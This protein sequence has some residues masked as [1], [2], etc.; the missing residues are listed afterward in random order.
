MVNGLGISLAGMNAAAH[1]L[2]NSANNVANVH[3]AAS[4]SDSGVKK[5]AFQPQNIM[6]QSVEPT[7]GVRTELRTKSNAT[8]P[9]S[10]PNNPAADKNG[11]VEYPNVNLAEEVVSQKMATYDYKANLKAMETIDSIMQSLLDVTA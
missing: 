9:V 7:G 6:R 8:V 10:E 11:M 1:Q 2:G 5:E 4:I 3:S